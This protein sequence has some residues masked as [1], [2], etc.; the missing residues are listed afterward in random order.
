M[1]RLELPC[2]RGCIVPRRLTKPSGLCLKEP[3]APVSAGS[4][5]A[6]MWTHSSPRCA[7]SRPSPWLELEAQMRAL[8]VA[9]PPAWTPAGD[10]EAEVHR[11]RRCTLERSNT[12]SGPYRAD[13]TDPIKAARRS[14]RLRAHSEL[15]YRFKQWNDNYGH[16]S[17]DGLRGSLRSCCARR[18]PTPV[19]S[20]R[21]MGA[22]SFVW[23]WPTRKNHARLNARND[24][25][26]A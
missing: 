24:C 21:A 3:C 19:I 1:N 9:A 10:H 12:A 15:V 23:C 16:A 8:I 26:L 4:T 6:A 18:R 14:A 5:P 2:A 11:V 22:M 20:L 25:E 7:K 17:G 13:T